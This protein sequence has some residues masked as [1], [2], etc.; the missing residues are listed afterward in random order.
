M[1]LPHLSF[2]IQVFWKNLFR[3][4][5]DEF[6]RRW[7]NYKNNDRKNARNEAC[8]ESHLLE[9]FKDEGHSGFPENVSIAIIDKADDKYPKKTESYWMRTRKVHVPFG[10]NIEEVPDQP[11]VGFTF[12]V[13]FGALVRPC[14][15]FGQ[16]FLDM[17][18]VF[19]FYSIIYF[20]ITNLLFLCNLFL[21]YMLLFYYILVLLQ[22]PGASYLTY[23]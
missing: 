15:N 19:C 21:C 17:T 16:D 20:L 13:F 8:M 7:N 10:L 9:H 22:L 12:L 4:T 3:E 5:T 23:F 11:H 14:T 6:R 18:Y 2:C 1:I